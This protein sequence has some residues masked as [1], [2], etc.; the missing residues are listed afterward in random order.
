MFCPPPASSCRPIASRGR[1]AGSSSSTDLDGTIAPTD[2]DW[3]FGDTQVGEGI[4]L[5]HTYDAAGTYTV[6]L[7]VTDNA[8]GTATA[9]QQLVVSPAA[10]Q[11]CTT[12]GTLVE[13]TLTVNGRVNVK[14]VVVSRSCQLTGN[15]LT[16]QAPTVQTIFFHLCNRNPG[17]EHILTAAGT[18]TPLVLNAGES[19]TFRFKQG[20]AGPGSPPTGDPGIQVDDSYPKWTVNIDDGG[21]AGTPGEPDFNDAILTVEATLA[22]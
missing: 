1:P 8:G 4:D 3:N 21:A 19:F 2:T 15:D 6:T 11:D 5:T 20:T 22:P 10:S 13:C 7:T 18:T 12:T 14:F 17:D 9:N 16:L